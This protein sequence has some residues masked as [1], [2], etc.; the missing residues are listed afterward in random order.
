MEKLRMT[1]GRR[2]DRSAQ[3]IVECVIDQVSGAVERIAAGHT[4]ADWVQDRVDQLTSL[5]HREEAT[6]VGQPAP[7]GIRPMRPE[8]HASTWPTWSD[9]RWVPVHRVKGVGW[10]WSE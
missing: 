4:I 6:Q 8:Q 3:N 10:V 2:D 7:V 9:N 5:M 1:A